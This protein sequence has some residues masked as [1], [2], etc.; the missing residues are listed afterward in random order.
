[1]KH[2]ILR[3]VVIVL[4]LLIVGKSSTII[5][6]NHGLAAGLKTSGSVYALGFYK[7]GASVSFSLQLK[8][9]PTT[10]L[11]TYNLS[12]SFFNIKLL[13]DDK[14][15]LKDF[16]ISNPKC[17]ATSNICSLSYR[18]TSAGN[19]NLKIEAVKTNTD[20]DYLLRY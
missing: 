17:K 15:I 18:T 12:P 13:R 11:G 4:V 20:I 19:V 5:Q 3:Y 16:T 10:A 9:F 6:S 2:N 1:M 14:S 7:T 8:D